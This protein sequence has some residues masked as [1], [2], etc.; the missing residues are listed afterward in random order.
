MFR[1]KF[2]RCKSDHS[3]ILV[4]LRISKYWMFDM[5]FAYCSSIFLVVIS[6]LDN[7]WSAPEG[8]QFREVQLRHPFVAWFLQNVNML[9]QVLAWLGMSQRWFSAMLRWMDDCFIILCYFCPPRNNE[10][11]SELFHFQFT[12][13][14]AAYDNTGLNYTEEDPNIFVGFCIRFDSTKH[15]LCMSQHI[16]KHKPRFQIFWSYGSRTRKILVFQ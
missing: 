10:D 11:L 4:V 1:K 5:L 12:S 13:I 14:V 7:L 15:R 8:A 9:M 6:V 2:M 3:Q 16:D